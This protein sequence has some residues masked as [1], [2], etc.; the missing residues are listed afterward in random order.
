MYFSAE[1]PLLYPGVGVR[2]HNVITSFT[3]DSTYVTNR[4][5]GPNQLNAEDG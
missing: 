3:D 2:V 1:E 5:A 4:T